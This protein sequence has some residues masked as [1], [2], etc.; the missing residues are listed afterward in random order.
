MAAELE[1]IR[2]TVD[3][4]KQE[5]QRLQ[6]ELDAVLRRLSTEY[7]LE[8]LSAADKR[9]SALRREQ[10]DLEDKLN[11]RIGE[12]RERYAELIGGVD[13]PATAQGGRGQPGG[14]GAGGETVAGG[15]QRG[16][17]GRRAVRPAGYHRG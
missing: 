4:A 14:R 15:G 2:H 10:E 11:K 7:K 8:S 12:V 9:L 5:A 17:P 3:A 1:D 16:G 13:V 6:G